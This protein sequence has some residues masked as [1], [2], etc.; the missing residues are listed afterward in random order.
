M[1]S[2]IALA[3]KEVAVAFDADLSDSD[4]IKLQM[5]V[6]ERH[7]SPQGRVA[8]LRQLAKDED[9]SVLLKDAVNNVL[10]SLKQ[11][12]NQAETE[13]LTGGIQSGLLDEIVW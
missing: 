5:V 8:Y 4:Q 10:L 9:A 2:L 11:Q 12:L 6:A 13:R 7:T 1:N 3:I